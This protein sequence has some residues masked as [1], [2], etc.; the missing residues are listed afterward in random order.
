MRL[1]VAR[2]VTALI[3]GFLTGLILVQQSNKEYKKELTRA[4][5]DYI[6]SLKEIESLKKRIASHDSIWS[7]ISRKHKD[8][9]EIERK[10]TTILRNENRRLKNRPVPNWT[11]D[12]LD[13]LISTIIHGQN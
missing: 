5:K 13:S 6:Q 4:K 11:N 10:N 8:S 2:I 7:E 3:L 12:D 9:L 1:T